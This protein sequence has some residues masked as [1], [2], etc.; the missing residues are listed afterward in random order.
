MKNLLWDVDIFTKKLALSCRS[1][2]CL[3][4]SA[5]NPGAGSHKK[6]DPSFDR[7]LFSMWISKELSFCFVDDH[8][9]HFI[10]GTNGVDYVQ[11][12]HYFSKTGMV[13]VE[14]GGVAA[15][16]ANEKL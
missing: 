5:T 9:G 13:A 10:A 14:M 8:L 12:F 6:R 3:D 2:P 7:S 15:T 1:N 11:T 4:V 16:V